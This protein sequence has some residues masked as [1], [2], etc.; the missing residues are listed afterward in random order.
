MLAMMKQYSWESID[1]EIV[2]LKIK[3]DEVIRSWSLIT[4]SSDLRLCL[5]LP[6]LVAARYLGLRRSNMARC[7]VGKN[8]LFESDNSVTFRFDPNDI[9]SARG[10]YFSISAERHSEIRELLLT[11]DVLTKYKFRILDIIRSQDP[12]HFQDVMGDN[13]FAKA[14]SHGRGMIEPFGTDGESMAAEQAACRTLQDGF[15]RDAMQFMNAGEEAGDPSAITIAYHRKLCFDWMH[16]DL[17]M[18]WEEVS[19]FSGVRPPRPVTRA[20]GARYSITNPEDVIRAVERMK[21][22]KPEIDA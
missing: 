18:S 3:F 13:F 17:G 2:R 6:K 1:P 12:I 14:A 16:A 7:R 19:V 15:R 5:F 20:I 9:R 4:S 11:L 22:L 21:K 8:I 10:I